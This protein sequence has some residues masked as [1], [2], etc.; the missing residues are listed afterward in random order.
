MNIRVE[1]RKGQTTSEFPAELGI[2]K[3]FVQCSAIQS[4][5]YNH[6]PRVFIPYAIC[7]HAYYENIMSNLIR[8]QS[9]FL[10]QICSNSP[11]GPV[12]LKSVL[13]SFFTPESS[14]HR[15]SMHVCCNANSWGDV[16]VV[17]TISHFINNF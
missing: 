13:I 15:H 12:Y 16:P 3:A 4:T 2:L 17:G 8:T 14:V 11:T 10:A 6:R 9:L 7:I 5:L 1:A